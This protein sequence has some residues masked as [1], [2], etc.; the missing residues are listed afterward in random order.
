MDT[1]IK[2]AINYLKNY[3]GQEIIRIKPIPIQRE[4]WKEWK[5]L[6]SDWRHTKTPI[7]LLGFT[8]EGAICYRYNEE[9]AR[10]NGHQEQVLP[11]CFTDENWIT[12]KEALEPKD[13]SLNKWIGQRIK[14]IRP[15]CLGDRSY[16]YEEEEYEKAPILLSASKYHML[17]QYSVNARTITCLLGPTF[18]KPE[19]WELA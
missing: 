19:D 15:T 1:T 10:I 2:E 9:G 4:E 7:I 8:K 17:I 12:Y 18:V 16:M 3:M 14:R 5:G 13:N 11:L 6:Q